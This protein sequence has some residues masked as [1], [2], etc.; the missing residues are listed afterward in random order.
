MT[1]SEPFPGQQ[2]L[3]LQLDLERAL[4]HQTAGRLPEAEGI[5]QKILQGAPHQPVALHQLGL[6]AYEVGKLDIAVELIG[7]ALAAK[8]DYA[9]AHFNLGVVLRGLGQLDAAAASFQNAVASLPDYGDA[10]YNLG[11]TVQE[12]GKLDEAVV[13]YGKALALKPN[14]AE[15]HNNL[16]AAFQDLGRLDEA[17]ASFRQAIAFRQDYAEAHSNLGT[18][19]KEQ[20]KFDEA[21]TSYQNAL[22][23]N[24]DDAEGHYI[25]GMTLQELGKLD[26]AVASYENALSMNPNFAEGHNNL[27]VALR[28]LGNLD[29]AIASFRT[30]LA[31]KADYAEAH[32][33]LGNT[34][35]E[36]DQLGDAVASFHKALAIKP[37][38]VE[39]HTN[40]GAALFDQG[41]LVRAVE[42]YHQALA[43]APD[44]AAAHSNLGNALKG[45][46]RLEEAAA[47]YRKALAIKPGYAEARSNLVFTLGYDPEVSGADILQEAKQWQ[48]QCG[49]TGEIPEHQNAPDPERQLRVG[50]V[51]G[52][53]RHHS[54]SYFLKDVLSKLDARK[55]ELFAYATFAKED[56][57]TARLK[58]IVPHW[59]QVSGRSD[60]Q[61]TDD[62]RADGIDILIDL[63]GHTGH[64]RL[65]VFS[66]KPAP[67]QV[68]WMGYGGTTGV[69]AMDY[70]LCD[71]QVL[72]PA[73]EAHYTEQP[74]RLPEVWMCF[75]PPDLEID[76]GPPPA[77]AGGSITFGSF[78]NL[79]KVS[80]HTVTCWARV[81]EAV[82]GS[83]LVLK[84]L[85]LGDATVQDAIVARFAAAGIDR[86]RLT[87]HGRFADPADHLRAYRK[88]DIAL[89]P[90]P[91]SG[92][93]T[94]AEALWM[95]TPVL[96][97]KGER[98]V[99]H[100]GESL[101]HN[102]GLDAWI[103][104]TPD[105]Y[106][107]K[108]KAFAADLPALAALRGSLRGQLL[109][110]PVCDAPRFASNLEDAFRGMWRQ[111]C[112]K[113]S[114]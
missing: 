15:G 90:F 52:D 2:T 50:L 39:A 98:Y 22:A 112:E 69:D 24:P 56:E 54:V 25:L 103:A 29:E 44:Y 16:G 30:A 45:L 14:F 63:S 12:L 51:S 77:V 78:N 76:A 13:S 64:N 58:S 110:S 92:G 84:A 97:L 20:G 113:R 70:I 62:I 9:K 75:S 18:V 82:P 57:M 37:D 87:F 89:D 94:T 28:S 95:G 49:F 93:T 53:L 107:A 26:E 109:A 88:I 71:P 46:G 73:E 38:Y 1:M 7:K 55:L 102:A 17:A 79:T 80:S 35:E 41:K 74:W 101:V 32:Y 104:E 96:T 6:I 61:L 91:Y 85:Q 100:M 21:V 65:A 43:I 19:F 106:V 83:R 42:R 11:V 40:L 99:A 27:G 10:Y 4:E 31:I 108:A 5:Y 72:P 111:W 34:F 3:T 59:R 67:V 33:N 48:V 60:Q 47:C 105:D 86:Q 8:P 23:I 81:L 114:A 36:L 68:T 66:R